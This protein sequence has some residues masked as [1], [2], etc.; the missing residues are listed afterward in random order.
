MH[1]I[2]NDQKK[3]VNDWISIYPKLSCR[4]QGT[5]RFPNNKQI[6]RILTTYYCDSPLSEERISNKIKFK[7]SNAD[8]IQS[9]YPETQKERAT[10]KSQLQNPEDLWSEKCRIV[11]TERERG[12]TF[13]V[14]HGAEETKIGENWGALERTLI[15]RGLKSWHWQREQKIINK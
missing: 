7:R 14:R 15:T 5:N 11:S 2:S 3:K 6:M 10:T 1:Q 13:D 8:I 9:L 4:R 12:R